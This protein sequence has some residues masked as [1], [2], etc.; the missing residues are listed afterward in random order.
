MT[1]TSKCFGLC[2]FWVDC[3]WFFATLDYR[4]YG[5][6]ANKEQLCRRCRSFKH[7][8]F[9]EFA[10]YRII[11]NLSWKK[12]LVVL[13]WMQECIALFDR[14]KLRNKLLACLFPPQFKGMAIPFYSTLNINYMDE[15]RMEEKGNKDFPQ[16]LNS[17]SYDLSLDLFAEKVDAWQQK[18]NVWKRYSSWFDSCSLRNLVLL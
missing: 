13:S 16:A 2:F 18:R 11:I 6:D 1:S 12:P 7:R 17:K 8:L 3:F 15:K 5:E 10:K 9:T 4:R 14:A